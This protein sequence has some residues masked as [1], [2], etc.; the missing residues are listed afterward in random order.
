M[1][2]EREDRLVP[3]SCRLEAEQESFIVDLAQRRVLGRN[4]SAVI[5]ALLNYAMQDMAKIDF[6]QKY[7]AMRDA[8]RKG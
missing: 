1:E 5:R 7:R 6:I 4:K 3:F 8:A 2:D